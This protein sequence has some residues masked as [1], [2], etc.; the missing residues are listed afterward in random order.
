[1]ACACAAFMVISCHRTGAEQPIPPVSQVDLPR[2]MGRWYVIAAIP[3][4]FERDDFDPVETY[5]LEPNGEICTRFQFLQGGFRG[6]LKAIHST[7]TIIAGTANAEWMVHLFWLLREQYIVAWLAPDYSRVIVARDARDY[8]WL[9]ARAPRIPED[10][11]QNMLARARAMGYAVAK[12]RKSPQ[13]GPGAG[14]SRESIS[15]ETGH[16]RPKSFQLWR[17]S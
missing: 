12:I 8:V 15:H 1:M 13:Q 2:Y 9:M 6:P 3:T 7:A 14:A 17:A 10:E 5:R 16:V 4:H 11:Y